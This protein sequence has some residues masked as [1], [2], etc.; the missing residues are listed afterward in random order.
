[1]KSSFMCAF[2]LEMTRNEVFIYACTTLTYSTLEMRRFPCV[3]IEIGPKMRK[4]ANFQ[5][6]QISPKILEIYLATILNYPKKTNN[7]VGVKTF[8]NAMRETAIASIARLTLV[9]SL[10]SLMY[11]PHVCIRV[12][13]RARRK[14]RVYLQNEENEGKNWRAGCPIGKMS[15]F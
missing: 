3:C 15:F 13:T 8:Q 9:N 10:S 12:G 5:K 14:T 4:N 7:F 2:I 11:V 1:M 6:M